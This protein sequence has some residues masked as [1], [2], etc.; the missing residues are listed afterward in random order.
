ME[1]RRILVV[2]E[3]D[4]FSPELLQCA[5]GLAERFRA[6]LIGFSAA[7]PRPVS[8]GVDYSGVAA[9]IYAEQL[10][11][12]EKRL[13]RLEQQFRAAVPSEMKTFWRQMIE[14]PDRGIINISR[15]ADLV[16][17]G[18]SPAERDGMIREPDP[19]T[20]VLSLGRPLLLVGSGVS[21][22]AADRIVVG[23]KDTREAR[24]AVADALPFLKAASAVMVCAV[25]EGD[26]AVAKPSLRDALDWMQ[27]HGVKVTG[28]VVPCDA[29]GLAATLEKAR[30]E[31]G[32][33]LVVTGAYG[34]S[35]MREWLLGGMTRELIEA[36]NSSRFMSN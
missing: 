30:V 36:Q 15:C 31:F 9:E 25:E 3:P 2:L 6:E 1:I 28:D 4:N 16:L 11:D 10:T 26:F 17:M 5:V 13:E 29:A 24:R 12:L 34:H 23:W 7:M 21:R 22:I 33:D 8:A 32:A 18:S 35:R 27:S 14:I 19:A 20:V